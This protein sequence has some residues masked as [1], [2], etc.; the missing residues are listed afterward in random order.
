MFFA[1][2]VDGGSTCYWWDWWF[3]MLLVCSMAIVGVRGWWFNMLLVVVQHAI[4]RGGSTCFWWWWSNMLL[5]VVVY[6]IFW[7]ATKMGWYVDW[8]WTTG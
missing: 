5:M 3:N 6:I 7:P 1:C 4:G 2:G 8:L